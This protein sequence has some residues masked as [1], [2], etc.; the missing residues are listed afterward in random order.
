M[1]KTAGYRKVLKTLFNFQ[2][3]AYECGSE[4]NRLE[5]LLTPQERT[6]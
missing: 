6:H 2:S 4:K 5:V 3:D 1:A